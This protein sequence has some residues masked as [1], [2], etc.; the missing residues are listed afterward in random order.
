MRLS[1]PDRS[2]VGINGRD[3]APTP[4]GFAGDYQRLF[5]SIS[6]R[7]ILS[8]RGRSQISVFYP[9]KLNPYLVP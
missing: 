7:R 1:N 9:Q 8:A 5:S 4:A 2:P 6:L 3:A